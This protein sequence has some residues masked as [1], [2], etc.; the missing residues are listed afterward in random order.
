M[1]HG[2]PDRGRIRGSVQVDL[3]TLPEHPASVAL[4][5]PGDNL[6]QSGLAG[7]VLTEQ[8]MSFASVDRQVSV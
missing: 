7:A 6:H 8:K 3:A 2:D 1:D 4:V 5:H